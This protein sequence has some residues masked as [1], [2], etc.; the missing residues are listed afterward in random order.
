[1]PIAARAA[2]GDSR[3]LRRRRSQET[4]RF[5]AEA[6]PPGHFGGEAGGR[7][8]FGAEDAAL[9]PAGCGVREAAGAVAA[10]DP[11]FGSE[12][13]RRDRPR[14]PGGG[15]SARSGGATGAAEAYV[16]PPA[17]AAAVRNT[18]C[19]SITSYRMPT[20]EPP[21]RT[22]SDCCAPL[23]TATATQAPSFGLPGEDRRSASLPKAKPV[24]KI[25]EIKAAYQRRPSLRR[26]PSTIGFSR[27]QQRCFEYRY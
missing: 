25:A 22:I 18:C 10:A 16:D 19:R 20:A 21:S 8:H 2:D 17:G 13:G 24:I 7:R 15:Q 4:S 26:R 5:G 27:V 6:G 11:N 9:R 1:M 23:I 12:G 14:Y 3:R